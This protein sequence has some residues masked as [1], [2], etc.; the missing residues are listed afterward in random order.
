MIIELTLANAIT[1]LALFVMSLWA[2]VKVIGAQQERRLTERFDALGEQMAGISKGQSNGAEL[3]RELEKAFMAFR[4]ELPRDYVRR[5]DF[6]RAIG[7]VETR[8]DNFA[9]RMERAL[10]KI[11]ERN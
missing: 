3:H 7:I 11:G 10:D 5:D 8:I 6:V 9:L 4:A 2:L 1:I